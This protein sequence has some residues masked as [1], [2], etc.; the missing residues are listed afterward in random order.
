M[1]VLFERYLMGDTEGEPDGNFLCDP[2]LEVRDQEGVE[3]RDEEM[4]GRFDAE[5]IGWEMPEPIENEFV[6][7]GFSHLHDDSMFAMLVVGVLVIIATIIFVKRDPEVTYTVLDKFGI[8][9]NF[10]LVLAVVPVLTGAIWFSQ[11]AIGGDEFFFKMAYCIPVLV[12]FTVAA[13]IALRRNGFRR[14]GFFIQFAGLVLLR[15]ILF[16]G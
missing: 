5:L 9:A 1:I 15:V 2:Y 4:L 12:T 13:S 11:I 6:F 8:A 16:F 10:V 3:Y 14:S 7:V